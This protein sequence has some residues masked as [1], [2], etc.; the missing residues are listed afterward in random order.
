MAGSVNLKS[1]TCNK[2]CNGLIGN[3]YEMPNVSYTCPLA[4]IISQVMETNH[5]QKIWLT[6][7]PLIVDPVLAQKPIPDYV[8]LLQLGLRLLTIEVNRSKSRLSLVLSSRLLR[9][10]KGKTNK[11]FV[12]KSRTTNKTK[13][14]GTMSC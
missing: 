11:N 12:E 2:H 3:R 7:P 10:N 6:C 14:T 8:L 1:N 13:P 4:A 9:D 5:M